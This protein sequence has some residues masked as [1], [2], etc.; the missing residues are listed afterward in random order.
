MK[1]ELFDGL[2][3][4]WAGDFPAWLREHAGTNDEQIERLRRNLQQVR[5]QEL[6]LR[7]QQVVTLYYDRKMN[8]PQIARELGVNQSTI[9]RTIRRAQE[10]LYHY[11]QDSL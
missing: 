6:T 10:R 4:N 11:L 3:S 5:E 1:K 2:Y 9:S 7:Q 8:V